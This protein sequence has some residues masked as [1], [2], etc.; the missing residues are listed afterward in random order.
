APIEDL[1]AYWAY[2]SQT[3]PKYTYMPKLSE[4]SAKRL[5]AEAEK[6]PEILPG[7]INALPR[8][9]E[10]SEFVKRLYDQ[11]LAN[12][13][14][15]RD[16]RDTVKR[17]LT[18]N[19]NYFSDEL[20][21]A[22]EVVAETED[23]VTNQDELLALARVDF[24]KARPILE[25][26]LNNRNAPVSQTLARWALYEHALREGNTSD[27]E[28]YRREL[29]STVENRGEGAGNRDLAMDALVYGGDYE[30]RDDWYYSLLSDETLYELRVG[31]RLYTGLTTLLNHSL[32]EKYVAKMLELVKSENKN[33]RN[34]AVRNLSTLI[35]QKN[36][37]IVK[38]LLPW[39]ENPN[40][41]KEVGG[42]RRALIGVLESMTIPESV[43]GLIA[44]LNEKEMREVSVPVY[45]GHGNISLSNTSGGAGGG[46]TGR[47]VE[48]FPFRY[49]AINA[50]AAQK[51]IRAVPALRLL[52]TQS[53]GYELRQVINALFLSGGYSIH[54]Q[55][56][57]LEF[58]AKNADLRGDNQVMTTANTTVN[59][60]TGSNVTVTGSAAV[61]IP[62]AHIGSS[63]AGNHS[64]NHNY[65]GFL[66]DGRALLGLLIAENAEPGSEL[67]AALLERIEVLESKEPN[68]ANALRKIIQNWRGA[69]VNSMLLKDLKNNK[70]DTD[71]IVKLLSLRKELKEKHFDEVYNAR[72]GG[73]S[74][75]YGISACL[76]ES[77]SDYDSIL[78]GEN[79]ESKIAMLGCARLIRA[80]LPVGVVARHLQSPNK[81]LA[82]AAERYLESEDS[83]EAR[84]LVLA[85]RPNEAKVLGAR[86]YFSS[87]VS[88]A[89][90]GSFL[91]D[92]FA[93]VDERF[94]SLPFYY[95][96]VDFPELT[97]TERK[98]Q[99]E[100][101]EN[102]E[103][104]GIYSYDDNF[105]RIYK[106]KAVF[107][108]EEDVSRYR[109]RVLTAEEFNAFKS[110]LASEKV[111]EIPPFISAC[112]E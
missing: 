89:V 11:E 32:P 93:S 30:G 5:L 94:L 92:L 46:T 80:Q 50:L 76:T 41:A 28:K 111:D 22:A 61:V 77:N 68:T 31:G 105:I 40:W 96:T 60:E 18:Y 43:P 109:E 91:R 62:R 82:L 36:P 33:V 66:K 54:E 75:A 2:Q 53:E 81:L 38:A 72:G 8:N 79:D 17:W 107:S 99:K 24:E 45:T 29:Q 110:Y 65:G 78:A 98:L 27:I 102:Q 58:I 95:L 10:T 101:K 70:L 86:N 39:L 6:D 87:G 26:L 88:T 7:L 104:L 49:M 47:Q 9:Q 84:M 51:D 21:K 3:N 73:S 97:A 56:E 69:A 108:W 12:R 100:V 15:E 48:Y 52:L 37:E 103:L 42:E 67:V 16:W 20:F 1:L 63:T 35:G 55:V 14:Y 106:D 25:R 74:I 13:K 64:Y 19:S 57:A 71:G 23:Y 112:D 59:A 83:P 4:E 90:N 44:V 34:A 85:R